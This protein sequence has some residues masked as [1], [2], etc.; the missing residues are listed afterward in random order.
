MTERNIHQ[1]EG[2]GTH[3]IGNAIDRIQ[4]VLETIRFGEIQLTIHDGT[5]VQLDVT[6]KHRFPA[7]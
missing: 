1:A 6:E 5:V 2:G 7:R 3:L 4:R